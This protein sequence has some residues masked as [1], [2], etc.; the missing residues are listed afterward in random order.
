MPGDRV[1]QRSSALIGSSDRFPIAFG[2]T[3]RRLTSGTARYWRVTS[4]DHAEIC[5]NSGKLAVWRSNSKLYI[6]FISRHHSLVATRLRDE[7][8]RRPTELGEISCEDVCS[9]EAA[10]PAPNLAG[11][12]AVW[13]EGVTVR[14]PRAFARPAPPVAC[15]G[16]QRVV[17]GLENRWEC[18]AI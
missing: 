18:I 16:P 4:R 8:L 14:I 9:R 1:S 15:H 17:L 11:S 13:C 3:T 2:T 7:L 10:D 12:P 5:G 6:R